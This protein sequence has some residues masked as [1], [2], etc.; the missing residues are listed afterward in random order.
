MPRSDSTYVARALL[1]D[2]LTDL[3]PLVPAEP[4]PLRALTYPQLL[5]S[6]RRELSALLNTRCPVPQTELKERERS[7]IDYGLTEL[8]WTSPMAPA[9]R[10]VLQT[11]IEQAISAFEPRLRHPHVTLGAYDSQSSCLECQVEGELTTETLREAVSF[12]ISIH[13]TKGSQDV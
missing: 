8:T 10:L 11:L 5:E 13:T 12:P 4:K 9:D 3:E 1:F 2:R 6:I 7:V